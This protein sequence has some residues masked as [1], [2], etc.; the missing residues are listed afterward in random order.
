MVFSEGE[1]QRLIEILSEKAGIIQDTWHKVGA[2]PGHVH[3]L[4][5]LAPS[6]LALPFPLRGWQVLV[7]IWSWGPSLPWAM[8]VT[9]ATP[10]LP[11]CRVFMQQPPLTFLSRTLCPFPSRD[12]MNH[13]A[14]A[15]ASATAHSCLGY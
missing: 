6:G 4:L 7:V 13:P 12:C 14:N 11:S 5:Q 1:A 2:L 9:L 8:P 10:S 15:L 3:W